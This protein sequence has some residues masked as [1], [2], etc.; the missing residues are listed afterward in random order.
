LRLQ[1]AAAHQQTLQN[2]REFGH[3][4]VG[5]SPISTARICAELWAQIK[6]EEWFAGFNH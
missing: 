6:D 5:A 1:V 3:L 2:A 4:R